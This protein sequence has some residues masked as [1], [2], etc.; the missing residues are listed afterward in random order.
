MLRMERGSRRDNRPVLKSL[1]NLLFKEL[2]FFVTFFIGIGEL[3]KKI[4][5]SILRLVLVPLRVLSKV[6]RGIFKCFPKITKIFSHGK[7]SFLKYLLAAKNNFSLWKKQAVSR[8]SIVLTKLKNGYLPKRKRKTRKVRVGKRV[9]P[10]EHISLKLRFFFLGCLL[11]LTGFFSYQSYAFVTN[12]PSPNTI[13]KVNYSL[14]T[15]IFDRSGNLLYEI[16]RDQNRTPV[17][18]KDLPSSVAQATIA[19]EDKDFYH[20]Q[21][22]SLVS[23]IFRAVREIVVKRSLQGG[24]TITQQLVKSA[25]L[26]PERTLQRKIKEIILAVWTERIFTK[27]QILEMYLNQ[28]PYGGSSYG[29]EEASRTYFGKHAK[30]LTLEESSLLAGLPQAP[31]L[32]SPFV[33]PDAAVARRND[34]LKNMRDLKYIT[35]GV[36]GKTRQKKLTVIPPKTGIKAPHFVFFVKSL[37]EEVYGIKEVE[38][39]GL[40]VTT[41][42]DLG[43]QEKAEE[44]LKE[45]LE[46][47]KGLNVTNG[48]ILVTRPPTGEILAMVGS[49]DYFATPSG[50]F[51]VTT[52]LRQ[53]G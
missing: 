47:V 21:G 3:T 16:Y 39:G 23:G 12:L 46:K 2:Y 15:H 9:R 50:A 40:N 43:I 53:P 11:T 6:E 28:V 42:L 30:D 33:N 4:I 26:T 25:L 34:V 27:D 17:K 10:L 38:E 20:H 22:V 7:K 49:A 13:G 37:L 41:T 51:N 29:I 24:S 14:S 18:L 19:I 31:S 45:E 36:Y 35:P 8:V 1:Y 48:A 52:A 5:I 44:I 32:Y